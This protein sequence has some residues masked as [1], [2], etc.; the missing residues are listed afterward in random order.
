MVSITQYLPPIGLKKF[1]QLKDNSKPQNALRAAHITADT[2]PHPHQNNTPP[3][4][5][6][7][8]GLVVFGGL[9]DSD[10][11]ESGEV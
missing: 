5:I 9:A 2:H 7:P 3:P 6:I 1:T 11:A 10:W 4:G 8:G